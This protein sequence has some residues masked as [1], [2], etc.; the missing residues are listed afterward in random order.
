MNIEESKRLF[1]GE[2]EFER[3]SERW[4][5]W[6]ADH[7][8]TT[9]ILY[10]L[11]ELFTLERMGDHVSGRRRK[12]LELARQYHLHVEEGG[13]CL[14]RFLPRRLFMQNRDLFRMAEGRRV[15]DVNFCPTNPETLSI[16]AAQARRF[17]QQRNGH[18]VFHIWPDKGPEEGWCSCPSCRAF[19]PYEQSLIAANTLAGALAETG[20]KARLSY[21]VPDGA[22]STL[23]CRPNLFPLSY[24]TGGPLPDRDAWAIAGPR[25]LSQDLPG[26]S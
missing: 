15:A 9:I 18:Q 22:E 2:V 10:P 26:P 19:S 3:D 24:P 20:S 7:G 17:F 14:S 11:D 21:L 23:Q 16:V 25:L 12:L 6:A 5:L 4:I 8:F 1:I 13:F